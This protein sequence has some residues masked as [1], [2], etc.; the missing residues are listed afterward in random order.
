MAAKF[1]VGDKVKVGGTKGV[2]C[3]ITVHD[4]HW[5][6]NGEPQLYA[7]KLEAW[8]KEVFK[9]VNGNPQVRYQHPEG[10]KDENGDVICR[11]HECDT[12][13]C[14]PEESIIAG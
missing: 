9:D 14:V 10:K 5:F 1:K 2:I 13:G 3:E 8:K 12:L 7:V 4:A 6:K 11:G